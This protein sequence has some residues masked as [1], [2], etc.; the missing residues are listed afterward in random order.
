[1]D[2]DTVR[3]IVVWS[4]WLIYTI[5]V[6]LYNM[7]P[8]A[9][10][11]SFSVVIE[12]I[13]NNPG[14]VHMVI[15]A[16]FTITLAFLWYLRTD[17]VESEEKE[18]SKLEQERTEDLSASEILYPASVPKT[19]VISDPVDQDDLRKFVIKVVGVTFN[20]EDG[21]NR[22]DVISQLKQDDS[23]EFIVGEY[24]GKPSVRIDSPKG[25]IGFVPKENATEIANKIRHEIFE[26]AYVENIYGGDDDK[27]YGVSVVVVAKNKTYDYRQ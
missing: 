14:A 21:V 15:W 5:Y 8:G 20:N 22:Q 18:K 25:T 10:R 19:P 26:K 6:F 3:D 16:L 11:Q 12:W 1:M 9:V 13:R 23:L 4:I 2:K 27:S 7:I 17:K 24:E